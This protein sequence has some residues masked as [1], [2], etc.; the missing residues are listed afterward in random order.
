MVNTPYITEQIAVLVKTES[1]YG[2]DAT[3][4]VGSDALF[5]DNFSYKPT[6]TGIQRQYKHNALNALSDLPGQTLVDI[7]FDYD[8]MTTGVAGSAVAAVSAL[9]QAAGMFV[10]ASASNVT[11]LLQHTASAN[12]PSPGKSATV[13]VYMRDMLY[14]VTGV[15]GSVVEKHKSDGIV[16]CSFTGKGLYTA[17]STA[18]VAAPSM[19]GNYVK[20]ASSSMSV[21]TYDPEWSEFE[22]DYG[23]QTAVIPYSGNSNGISKIMITGRQP[24]LKM[25]TL[26]DTYSNHDFIGRYIGKNTGSLSY[27]TGTGTGNKVTYSFP[28]TQYREVN[29]TDEDTVYK[30]DLTINVAGD[31]TKTI[32]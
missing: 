10:S 4:S 14:K 31:F 28:T 22:V 30:Y 18:T 2:T 3:P 17:A 29:I 12:F 15:Y 1:S 6:H 24:V 16:K 8:Y 27:V 32:A 21:H 23:V 20:V 9:E 25:K 5:V 19:T 7:S 26:M 13:Y 11:Y